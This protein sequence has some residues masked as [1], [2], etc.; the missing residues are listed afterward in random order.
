MF[1]KEPN[2]S[3]IALVGLLNHL[4]KNHISFLDTQML[5]PV[6]EKLGGKPIQRTTFMEMLKEA[7]TSLPKKD[8]FPSPPKRN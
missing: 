5:T 8:V 3:K 6:I 7:K 4:N 1:F 2:T